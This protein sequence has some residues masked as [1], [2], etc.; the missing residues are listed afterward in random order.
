MKLFVIGNGFDCYLHQLPTKYSDFRNFIVKRYDIP[1]TYSTSDVINI[2]ERKYTR[3]DDWD[4]DIKE[5]ARYVVYI[6]DQCGGE[7][8]S[9]LEKYLGYDVYVPMSFDLVKLDTTEDYELQHD[10]NETQGDQADDIMETFEFL[11]RFFYEWVNEELSQVTKNNRLHLLIEN[12]RKLQ[13]VVKIFENIDDDKFLNFNYTTTLEDIYDIKNV[14]HIH[15]QVG[16]KSDDIYFGHGDDEELEA[17]GI[18]AAAESSF[19][20]LKLKLQK[21]TYEALSKHW[22]FFENLWNIDEVYSYG[23]SF[24]D[25]DM[26]YVKK[27]YAQITKES[28][29]TNNVKWFLNSY[30]WSHN[31]EYRTKLE[32]IGF[33]VGCENRW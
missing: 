25:V 2:P 26:I 29:N 3:Y 7:N 8:W 30:D 12:P 22:D 4:Y 16:D 23:F 17:S 11:K 24:S 9:E 27:I 5:I 31:P 19:N 20:L 33:I 32:K 10:D 15:G 21:D 6:I 1:D 28:N 14:C 13:K 18:Y